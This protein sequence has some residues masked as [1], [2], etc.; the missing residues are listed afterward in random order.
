METGISTIL[1]IG[2]P[3]NALNNWLKNTNFPTTWYSA[4][5]SPGTIT[6]PLKM[7]QINNR[8]VIF[9]QLDLDN[10]DNPD[11]QLFNEVNT[12]DSEAFE[13]FELSYSFKNQITLFSLDL[14]RALANYLKQESLSPTLIGFSK[15]PL[16]PALADFYLK[17]L[18]G[19]LDETN[20][21]SLLEFDGLA[22]FL[23]QA[24]EKKKVELIKKDFS[25]DSS[26]AKELFKAISDMP[27]RRH[28]SAN[29]DDLL[30]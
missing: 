9:I 22:T 1:K 7:A 10:S 24:I 2:N 8:S 19:L 13:S 11:Y 30:D 23:D 17:N 12:P 15:K 4:V 21:S 25:T 26:L 18:H 5:I 16:H 28:N 3:F 20:T 29:L 6:I 27:N 14:V